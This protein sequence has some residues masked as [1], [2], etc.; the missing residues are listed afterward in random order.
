[1]LRPSKHAHPDKTVISASFIIIKRLKTTR[2]NGYEELR[3]L[4]KEKMGGSESL[5]LPALNLLFILGL[6]QY[7]SKSDSIEYIGGNEI[8]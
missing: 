5:F 3:A 7:L 6:I 4:I 8:I 1:M 2:L